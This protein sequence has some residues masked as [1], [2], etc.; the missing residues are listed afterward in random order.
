MYLIY[1][2][3]G[4]DEFSQFDIDRFTLILQNDMDKKIR[5]LTE[6]LNSANRKCEVYRANLLSVLKDIDDHKQQLSV[7]VQNIKLSM[8]DL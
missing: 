2:S 7:K 6:E 1:L 3:I 8:K 4:K 5:E